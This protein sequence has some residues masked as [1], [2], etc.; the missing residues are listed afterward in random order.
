MNKSLNLLLAILVLP[1]ILI[2]L[3]IISLFILVSSGRPILYWSKRIGKDRSIFLMPKFRT[4]K[5]NTPELAT[6]LL[7]EPDLFLTPEGKFLRKSSLDEIPQIWCIFKGEMNFVGPRPALHSQ[8]NLIE[9]RVKN[10]LD[11]MMPGITGWA[12]INGRDNLL[13]PEKV[14]LER[15]YQE[16]RSLWFDCKILWLTVLKVIKQDSVSH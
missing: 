4:M 5:N 14:R 15:E 6:H 13:I 3:F 8:S 9:L 11:A 12:Q 10:N 2:P 1:L 16:R 7:H